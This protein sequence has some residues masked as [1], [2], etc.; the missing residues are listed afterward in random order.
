L[1]PCWGT[2]RLLLLAALLVLLLV[3]LLLVVVVTP[4]LQVRP[5]AHQ[6]QCLRPCR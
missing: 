4:A 5:P 3:L 6:Q 1:P 2:C